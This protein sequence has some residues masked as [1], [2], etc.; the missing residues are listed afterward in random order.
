MDEDEFVADVGG[1]IFA[2]M[3]LL[4]L[5]GKLLGAYRK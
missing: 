1:V 3:F 4:A 2:L 5:V